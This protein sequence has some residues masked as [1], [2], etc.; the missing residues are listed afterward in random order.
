MIT[1]LRLKISVE[2]MLR[3]L[4]LVVLFFL[5]FNSLSLSQ[6]ESKLYL[7][8]DRITGLRQDG[9]SLWVSTYGHGIFKYDKQKDEWEEFSTKKGNI[10]NDFFYNVAVGPKYVWAGTVDGLFIYDKKRKNWRKRKFALG[11]E[12]GNWIR[13]LC[14]DPDQNVLWIGRFK[15]LTRLDVKRNR[16]TD[17]D[18]VQNNDSKS[19][20]FTTIK[21]DGDSLIWFGTEA[22]VYK[23]YKNKDIKAPG[24]F[25]FVE[26]KNGGFND[27]GRSVTVL[28]ILFSNGDVWF[29]TAEFVTKEQPDFNPGGIYIF[30][31]KFNWSRI[32]KVDGLPGNGIYC[33]ARTGNKIWAGVYGFDKSEKKEY[34][35]GIVLID[36]LSGIVTPIDLN[37]ID[38]ETSTVFGL[39]FDGSSMWVASD[40]GLVK[41][42]ISNPLAR[43]TLKKSPNPGKM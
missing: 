30:D 5:V 33:L 35:K 27:E 18:M 28:D 17:Y 14:Y 4:N 7:K 38:I 6:V 25:Q 43:W 31:R 32:S 21:L 20:T 12:M 2:F 16:Y 29:G 41:I 37:M 9:S 34:G 15:N 11:G 10:T 40:D 26:N 8:G 23:Y 36:R 3:R 22:G 19:N 1:T 13:S 42:D 39:Y 24:A